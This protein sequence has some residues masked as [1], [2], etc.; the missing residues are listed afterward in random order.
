MDPK[1]VLE[2]ASKHKAV[3]LDLRFI[4]VPG[5]W[6]HVSYPIRELTESPSRKDSD[7]TPAPFAGGNR[8]TNRTCC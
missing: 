2:Y 1:S 4:D 6:Q 8:S 5:V 3:I 7:W